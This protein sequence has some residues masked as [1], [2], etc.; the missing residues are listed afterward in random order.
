MVSTPPGLCLL[1]SSG[2]G[3]DPWMEPPTQGSAGVRWPY[4]DLV[5]GSPGEWGGCPPA[6][7]LGTAALWG[8]WAGGEKAE[9]W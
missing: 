8:L 7:S 5:S 1:A 6:L 3:A 9:Q 2:V 4:S